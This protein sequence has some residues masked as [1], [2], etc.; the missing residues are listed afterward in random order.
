ML[1][2]HKIRKGESRSRKFIIIDIAFYINELQ[3]FPEAHSK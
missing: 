1:I 3:F 2:A